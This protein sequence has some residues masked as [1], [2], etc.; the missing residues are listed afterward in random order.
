M[1][2]EITERDD[3]YG[4][5]EKFEGMHVSPNGKYWGTEPISLEKEKQMER[6]LEGSFTKRLMRKQNNKIK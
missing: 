4:R 2:I 5:Y 1:K 3:R 6:E